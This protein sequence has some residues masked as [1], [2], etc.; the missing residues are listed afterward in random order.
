MKIST[1][2]VAG[3]AVAL[4]FL[5]T[6]TPVRADERQLLPRDM[7]KTYVPECGACHTAYPPGMLPARSWQ[8]LMDGLNQHY[9]TD[10]S[11]DAATVHE[12]GNWLQAHAGRYKRSSAAPP[13]D[14]IT[15]T[16]WFLHEHRKIDAAVWTHD[17]VGSA[18]QCTACHAGADQG[19]YDDDGLRI[20]AGLDARLR[21]AWKD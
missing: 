2:R 21:R 13:Q 16:A 11:L 19:D 1:H 6:M 14:R 20:P 17:S 10:A 15:R 8:R 3:I 9:G 7:P 12:L 4:L 5:S 18:A